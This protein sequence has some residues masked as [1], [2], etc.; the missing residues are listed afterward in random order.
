MTKAA[1]NTQ[2][3]QFAFTAEGFLPYS[4]AD[5]ELLS[6]F[7]R[8]RFAALY[9]ME[10]SDGPEAAGASAAFLL[11]LRDTFFKRLTDLPDL[12]LLIASQARTALCSTP[13]SVVY[14]FS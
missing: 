7:E 8:D 11:L 14:S 10:P 3:L 13:L 4:D 2:P 6:R 12:E 5:R 1:Q 9:H